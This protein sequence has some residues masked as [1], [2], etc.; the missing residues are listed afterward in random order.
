MKKSVIII[1]SLQIYFFYQKV[2]YFIIYTIKMSTM[3]IN[4]NACAIKKLHK[5]GVTI[6]YDPV[7]ENRGY[8]LTPSSIDG[9]LEKCAHF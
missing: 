5:Y 6:E 7:K 4:I 3:I 9:R 1:T 2:Y 8:V